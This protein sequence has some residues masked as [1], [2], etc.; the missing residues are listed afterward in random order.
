MD[1]GKAE[2]FSSEITELFLY[3]LDSVHIIENIEK[4]IKEL[5]KE[6]DWQLKANLIFRKAYYAHRKADLKNFDRYYKEALHFTAQKS[7]YDKFYIDIFYATLFFRE[8][9]HDL[10]KAEQLFIKINAEARQ[11]KLH[12]IVLLLLNRYADHYYWYEEMSEKALEYRMN[13]M[14]FA[15]SFAIDRN[16]LATIF[17]DMGFANYRTKNYE[18]AKNYFRKALKI[19]KDSVPYTRPTVGCIN[20]IGLCFRN[21]N[22]TDSAIYFFK[23]SAQL[24]QIIKD[25]AWIGIANGNIGDVYINNKEYKKAIPFLELDILSNKTAKEWTQVAASVVQLALC[26]GKMNNWNKTKQLLDSAWLFREKGVVDRDIERMIIDKKYFE[27]LSAYYEAQKDFEN[28]L[29]TQRKAHSIHD[30]IQ[31]IEQEK[32]IAHLQNE[33]EVHQEVKENKLLNK[34]NKLHKEIILQQKISNLLTISLLLIVLVFAFWFYKKN[35]EQKMLNKILQDQ[36]IVIEDAHTE[37]NQKNELLSESNQRLNELLNE[38]KNT[39][40]KLIQSEKMSAL[41]TLT[42]GIA[43]EINNPINFVYAGTNALIENLKDF[44]YILQQ[45]EQ[46]DPKSSQQAWEH[47]AK[48][49]RKLDYENL[50]IEILGVS[51]DIKMGAERVIDIVK[52]L[53]TFSRSEQSSSWQTVDIVPNIDAT[54]TILNHQIKHKVQIIK[55]YEAKTFFIECNIGEINQIF[56][57]LI[58]NAIDAIEKEGIIEIGLEQKNPPNLLISEQKYLQISIK[59]N[60]SGIPAEV[61]QR[62]FESFFT[63]KAIGKGTGLGLSISFGIIEKH[64]GIILL[65]SQVGKGTC[66][67]I[68]LPIRQD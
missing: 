10:A 34:E 59:D 17:N 46:L 43:H 23:K 21:T 48:I 33:F 47:L 11:K 6:V 22:Q 64:K 37:T 61:Q 52:S 32:N 29:I 20:S 4:I 5:P 42:A 50:K 1:F 58:G 30:T 25:T 62:I 19:Y 31:N 41:G 40:I 49:K 38:L 65:D 39:Q 2:L 54:L 53:K 28:A 18:A 12:N 35:K 16:I 15:D 3:P 51:Q 63:T 24:A 26:Y 36:K 66:F 55:K 8:P 27:V 57:N 13:A 9:L 45:Y 68:Y 60:G 56:M 67:T 44:E 7:W 14:L